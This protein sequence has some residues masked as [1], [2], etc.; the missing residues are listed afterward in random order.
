MMLLKIVC[1]SLYVVWSL[2]LA[3]VLTTLLQAVAASNPSCLRVVSHVGSHYECRPCNGLLSRRVEPEWLWQ[4]EVDTAAREA[5]EVEGLT[6]DNRE[7]SIASTSNLSR[8]GVLFCKVGEISSPNVSFFVRPR[9]INSSSSVERSQHLAIPFAEV[10]R[11]TA[12]HANITISLEEGCPGNSTT[13]F[14]VFSYQQGSLHTTQALRPEDSKI[15]FNGSHFALEYKLAAN[16]STVCLRFEASF[17]GGRVL[18]SINLTITEPP[19]T[20]QPPTTETTV[21]PT[22]P[23]TETTSIATPCMASGEHRYLVSFSEPACQEAEQAFVSQPPLSCSELSCQDPQTGELVVYSETMPT[24][25]DLKDAFRSFPV[26]SIQPGTTVSTPAMPTPLPNEVVVGIACGAPILLLLLILGAFSYLL[27]RCH[28]KH[29]KN[30]II[31]HDLEQGVCQDSARGVSRGESSGGTSQN[32]LNEDVE[33]QPLNNSSPHIAPPAPP[34]P[35]TVIHSSALQTA[36]QTAFVVSSQPQSP[37][38]APPPP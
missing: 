23:P 2:P 38:P 12:Q 10:G 33:L 26:R 35:G 29:R 5:E 36:L 4:G 20:T 27:I 17:A 21:S 22:E 7:L 13:G 3:V 6:I 8:E 16:K 1:F 11:Q 30:R 32:S 9:A 31:P 28:L 18:S 14:P 15:S 24:Q 25:E 37:P 19:T 34:L